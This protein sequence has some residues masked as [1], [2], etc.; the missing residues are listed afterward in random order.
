MAKKETPSE[1]R[2]KLH[3]EYV[4]KGL[5]PV[6]DID[7]LGRLTPEDADELLEAIR[8]QRRKSREQPPKR[9]ERF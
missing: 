8:E 2:R 7:E 6:K 9:R 1:R 5:K 3:L 4:A